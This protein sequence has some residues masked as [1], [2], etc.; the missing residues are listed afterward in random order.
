MKFIFLLDV[1][2]VFSWGD[3]ALGKLGHGNEASQ[4][5]PRFVCF[6]LSFHLV[7][8]VLLVGGIKWSVYYFYFSRRQAYCCY[9]RYFNTLELTNNGSNY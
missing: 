1:G 9:F 5:F 4:P 3:G 6:I 8:D 7:N 2:E